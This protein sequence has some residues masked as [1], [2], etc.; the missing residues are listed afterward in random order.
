[1][2][3]AEA[4]EREIMN[5]RSENIYVLDD[6][7]DPSVH[8]LADDNI[9]YSSVQSKSINYLKYSSEITKTLFFE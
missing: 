3:Q 6:R 2:K 5:S 1:M 9:L 7:N 4:I 8:L